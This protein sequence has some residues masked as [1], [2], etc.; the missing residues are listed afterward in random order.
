M[1]SMTRTLP[2]MKVGEIGPIDRAEWFVSRDAEQGRTSRRTQTPNGYKDD[3][4]EAAPTGP[5]LLCGWSREC[6]VRAV[7]LEIAGQL[8]AS[9]QDAE[10]VV[11][12]IEQMQRVVAARNRFASTE[13]R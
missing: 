5:P 2:G 12:W 7:Y 1:A 6:W 4:A 11:D 10:Y 13:D 8:T 3:P 9:R